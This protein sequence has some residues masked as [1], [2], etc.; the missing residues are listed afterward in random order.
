MWQCFIPWVKDNHADRLTAVNE[1]EELVA[2]FHQNIQQAA[3]RTVLQ[4]PV[5]GE[6]FSLSN[7]FLDHLR[8]D[9]GDLSAF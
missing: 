5:V 2:D 7:T 8:H 3:F 6:L 9:Y 4:Q 1:V